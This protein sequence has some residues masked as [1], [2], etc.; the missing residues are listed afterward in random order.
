MKKVR[1]FDLAQIGET[2]ITPQGFLKVPGFATRTGVFTYRDAE[3]NVRR[4]LRH[5]DDVFNE[6]SL[7]T[8]QNAPVTLEHPPEMVNPQNIN[9]YLKGYCTDKVGVSSDLVEAEL[10]VSHQDAIDAIN[11]GIRELSSGYVADLEEES[12]TY[13]G[14]EYDYRQRNIKYNH[15]ALVTK[16]RAGPQVRL[17]LDSAD[18]VMESTTKDTSMKVKIGDEQIEMSDKAG[19]IVKDMFDSYDKM[20]ADMAKMSEKMDMMMKKD[21]D[22]KG[23]EHD[24]K[25]EV[26]NVPSNIPDDEMAHDG[27]AAS[28]KVGAGDTDGP[29]KASGMDE[30]ED[31]K[32]DEDK[33]SEIA[34]LM[35]EKQDLMD[36]MDKMEAQ[37]DEAASKTMNTKMDSADVETKVQSKLRLIRQAER[38]VGSQAALKFD[39]LTDDEIRAEVI[40]HVH[41]RAELDGK[42]S[43]YLEARFDSITEQVT[44]AE[45]FRKGTEATKKQMAKY[46]NADP[47]AARAAYIE[48]QRNAWKSDLTKKRN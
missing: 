7:K 8:L 5:P 26:G 39:S 38:V 25:L 16:G 32:K 18:A 34:K 29:L 3:G 30:D 13:N 17:R 40:K 31:E 6:E 36:K 24:D 35:K 1:R 2:E 45:S 14:A 23:E 19:A 37:M 33:D 22:H 9:S 4:E 10:I 27:K 15:V 47:K 43:V 46:D 44:T 28:K 11:G 12:G 41:P 42:S 20:K 48:E 21:A